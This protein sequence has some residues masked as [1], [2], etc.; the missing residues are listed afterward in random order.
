ML[1]FIFLISIA[2][3]LGSIP[4]GKLMGVRHGIDIQKYGSGNIGFA[5]SLRV[6]GLKPA[7]IVLV[8]DILKGFLPVVLALRFLPFNETLW[9]SLTAILAH[10]F[11]IW[12]KFKGGKGIATALGV[13]LAL[14]PY[15]GLVGAF[16][17]IVVLTITK[18][19]S[20]ASL[21]VIY[22]MPITAYFFSRELTVFYVILLVVGTWTH[23][24]NMH[25]LI[26]GTEKGI[27]K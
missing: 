16:I 4:F 26:K 21:I 2:Y 8:G 15:L 13:T 5:N 7:L 10:I 17:W 22:S 1:N 12:L 3:F 23:R 6:L 20:L 11:P 25:H 9:V 19:N 27:I 18:L 24:Q 14:N